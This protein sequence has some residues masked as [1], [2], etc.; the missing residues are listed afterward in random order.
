[1][2]PLGTT[3]P[4]IAILVIAATLLGGRLGLSRLGGSPGRRDL[5]LGLGLE[6]GI[7][8]GLQ[9]G[10]LPVRGRGQGCLEGLDLLGLGQ[11]GLPELLGLLLQ[12]GDVALEVVDGVLLVLVGLVQH[13]LHGVPVVDDGAVGV[14]QAL[15]V[16][17]E[18]LHDE[19]LGGAEVFVG[20]EEGAA[21]LLEGLE[22]DVL[23]APELVV[24]EAE[25]E[26]VEGDDLPDQ[27]DVLLELRRR[28]LKGAGLVPNGLLHDLPVLPEAL[29]RQLDGQA[30]GPGAGHRQVAVVLEGGGGPVEGPA[31]LRDAVQHDLPVLPEPLVAVLDGPVVRLG[32]S[33][34]DGPVLPQLLGRELDARAGVGRGGQDHV[35]VGL[36]LLPDELEAQALLLEEVVDHLPLLLGVHGRALPV[37]HG[38]LLLLL[39]L[40]P[41]P[42]RC[43]RH[44]DSYAESRQLRRGRRRR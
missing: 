15:E 30:V 25:G 22:D 29:G 3:G 44:E 43:E 17:L 5:R 16:L 38:L 23:V 12:V 13:L 21:V 28:V 34:G 41:E 26:A 6:G 36:E 24:G 42:Y 14:G 39:L 18:A 19:L 27:R 20:E 33:D 31:V 10:V 1:M 35:V 40:L 8:P 2:G 4:G 7:G 11:L 32:R 9:E 37:G